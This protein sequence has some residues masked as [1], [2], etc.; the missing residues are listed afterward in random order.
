MSILSRRSLALG[1]SGLA[2]SA[3]VPSVARGDERTPI[4]G[5]KLDE[6]FA[7]VAR[8]RKGAKS[9]AGPFTQT[10]KMGLMKAQIVSQGRVSLV[11]PDR[12][13]WELF[14]P[15]E[16]VYFVT[17]DG[18]AYRNRSSQGAVRAN[19]AR[20]LAAGLD[21]LRAMLG[22]DLAQLRKRYD[23]KAFAVGDDVELEANALPSAEGRGM[24]AI[25]F[26]IG[27]D[28]IRPTFTRL[29]EKNG[30]SSDIRFGELRMNVP[31]DPASMH[32]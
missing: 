23:L 10:R 18:L 2:M 28:R 13:R 1:A 9:F 4:T 29:V 11:L 8:A 16:I 6:L 24:K 30:D 7:E 14:P 25:K 22:G 20:T 15:D 32:L 26:G 17:P 19:D 3:L 27:K 21:D 31:I 5:A 12:L